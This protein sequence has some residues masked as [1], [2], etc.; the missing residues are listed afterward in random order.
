MI[1]LEVNWSYQDSLEQSTN[2]DIRKKKIE[3]VWDQFRNNIVSKY[4]FEIKKKQ[5]GSDAGFLIAQ[6]DISWSIRNTSG[7]KTILEVIHARA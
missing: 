7:R 1:H 5:D 3:A 4:N 2:F 6:T